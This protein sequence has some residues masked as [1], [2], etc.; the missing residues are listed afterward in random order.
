[1]CASADRHLYDYRSFLTAGLD[2][3]GRVDTTW[4]YAASVGYR[5][6]RDGRVGFGA[7]YIQRDS[8]I[9]WRAY[10]NLRFGSTFSYGL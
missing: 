3:V 6:G 1:M 7:A 2:D 5:V 8:T 10:D 9:A 4:Y